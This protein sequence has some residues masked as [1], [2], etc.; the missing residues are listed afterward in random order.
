MVVPFISDRPD[1]AADTGLSPHEFVAL[2]ESGR[3]RVVLPNGK[4][5][6]DASL[7]QAT[8]S[9]TLRVRLNR[10]SAVVEVDG[11]T[12][13]SGQ[14]HLSPEHVRF[15]GVR[16]LARGGERSTGVTIKTLKLIEP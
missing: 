3:V 13:W 11:K 15:A 4:T 1:F 8:G 5:A 9:V 16:F 12:L 6:Q 7:V 14:H 10:D 2:I